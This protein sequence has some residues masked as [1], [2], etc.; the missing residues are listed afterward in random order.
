MELNPSICPHQMS[1]YVCCDGRSK[2]RLVDYDIPVPDFFEGYVLMRHG[3]PLKTANRRF[4]DSRESTCRLEP[5]RQS[6]APYLI[7][8]YEIS[9]TRCATGNY[10]GRGPPE[11]SLR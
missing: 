8:E 7:C 5:P 11:A 9:R 4:F 3:L 1:L 2:Q 10:R 6:D